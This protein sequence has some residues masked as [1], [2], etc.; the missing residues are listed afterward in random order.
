M[1]NPTRQPLLVGQQKEGLDKLELH[2]FTNRDQQSFSSAAVGH[3]SL[4]EDQEIFFS[5]VRASKEW[6]VHKV[7]L[8]P[9]Q[10]N[11][12]F[13]AA[14]A[15]SAGTGHI[16]TVQFPIYK[17]KIK[18]V[19]KEDVRAVW[20]IAERFRSVIEERIEIGGGRATEE[21]PKTT[22]EEAYENQLKKIC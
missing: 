7:I 3:W 8:N 17:A 22:W 18:R 19:K 20:E 2:S 16:G 1:K 21:D 10:Q 4:R 9:R 11:G 5:L 12:E 15:R 14:L 13:W 6:K